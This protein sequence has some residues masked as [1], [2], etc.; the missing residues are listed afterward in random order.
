M[1]KGGLSLKLV[2]EMR[3]GREWRGIDRRVGI[4]TRY[5]GTCFK[6]E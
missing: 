3:G 1:R 2:R 5:Y 4:G 6:K